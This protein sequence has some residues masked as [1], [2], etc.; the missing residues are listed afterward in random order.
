MSLKLVRLSEIAITDI[1]AL[2]NDH[3]N[4]R[5]LPLSPG[6]FDEL[7]CQQWVSD[8]ESH[9]KTNGYGPWGILINGEF[10]GWGGLQNEMGDA[11]LALVLSPDY[12][13]YGRRI[14]QKIFKIAF[15]EIGLDSVTALLP[16]SRI[17]TKGM[18]RL[19]FHP[20]GQVELSGSV[21]Y[22]F[23]LFAPKLT[24]QQGA[25]ADAKDGAVEL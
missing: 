20:D 13:G 24:A 7:R 21:F 14:C 5:H 11:D 4:L 8:K 9:W 15:E 22:R 25:P 2:H 1:M 23:R 19:G 12:W 3:R 17:R 6:S 18:L 16:P 10:A